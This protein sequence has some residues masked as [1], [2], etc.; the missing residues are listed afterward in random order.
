MSDQ[1][2]AD[3]GA[4]TTPEAGDGERS[5][6]SLHAEIRE[7]FGVLPNFF[8]LTP[9]SPE[10]TA[11]LWGFARFAYLDNPLDSL[12]KERLFVYLSRFC[13]V[14]YCIT[15]HVGFLLGLG[16]P[17]GDARAQVQSVA[18]VIRLLRRPLP[19]GAALEL[20]IELCDRSERPIAD[21]PAPE[22]EMECALFAC[23]SHAFLQTNDARRCTDALR[24]ALGEPRFHQL[25]TFLAFVRTAHYWS[26]VHSDLTIEEDLVALLA[27]HEQLAQYLL[28]DP[29]AHAC[30]LDTQ[31]LSELAELRDAAADHATEL[32]AQKRETEVYFHSV[33]GAAPIGVSVCD[34]NGVLQYYNPRAVELWG[35]EPPINAARYC[36]S[37]R[38]WLPSGVELAHENS[39][40]VEVLRTGEPVRDLE[41]SIE[42]PD[43]SRVPVSVDF[44]ALKNEQG[45]IT[46]GITCFQDVTDRKRQEAA[47][48]DAG[49]RK[50]EFL[51]TLAHELRNPLAPIS[52]SLEILRE[53]GTDREMIDRVR[54]VMARQTAHLVR[55]VDDLMEV[56]RITRDRIELR[57]EP[58][59][60]AEIVRTAV[61][62]SQPLID[63]YEHRL[64][65][66]LPEESLLLDADPVRIAQV[67][68]NLLN[69]ATKY[70]DERGQIRL[71]ARREGAHA[72]ISVRDDGIGIAPEM[73]DK[74]FDLFRQVSSPMDRAQGGLGIGLTLVKRLVEMHG[75]TVLARSAGVGHGTEF[76]VRLPLAEPRRQAEEEP[77][78][79]RRQLPAISGR[80]ILVIDDHQDSANSLGTLLRLSG[81]EVYTAYDGLSA[82]Q[83][84]DIHRPSIVFVDI[85]MPGMDGYEVARQARVRFG[86][87]LTLIALSGWGQEETIR[88]SK[89]AGMDH[90]LVKPVDYAAL[91]DLLSSLSA[92]DHDPRG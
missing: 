10:T 58:I 48:Q 74:V 15:R 44:S 57:K 19:R 37:L 76:T 67:L 20:L 21:L 27:A 41:V 66:E 87:D 28:H 34:R 91:I 51:A 30:E 78:S 14:R 80:R 70:T 89:A 52:N 77:K 68:A 6:E 81:A 11:N 75:G 71:T 13:N 8:R 64:E 29:E 38:L 45:V 50:D 88:R 2:P 82:L 3:G 16:R 53:C 17:S 43:G 79:W 12:F 32:R 5:L 9:E 92:P 46:G 40:I 22:T 1:R 61:E 85:G 90:H 69:N 59:D 36:G 47:L 55:L 4:G 54:E 24:H 42:R 39:P 31:L 35:R 25:L 86:R 18:D 63:A 84:I 83:A 7:R 33:L 26:K 65:V 72:S 60:L 73:L 23:A 62:T 56:S 49:R